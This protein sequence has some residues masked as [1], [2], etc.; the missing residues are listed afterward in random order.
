MLRLLPSAKKGNKS[1]KILIADVINASLEISWADLFLKPCLTE[2]ADLCPVLTS[3]RLVKE[4]GN[5][6]PWQEAFKKQ[7]GI[8]ANVSFLPLDLAMQVYREMQ[9]LSLYSD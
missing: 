3:L 9:L 8:D 2:L 5:S 4:L 7:V 1:T 6:A